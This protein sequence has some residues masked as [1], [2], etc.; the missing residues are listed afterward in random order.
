MRLACTHTH[1]C[2]P[3]QLRVYLNVAP[4]LSSERAKSCPFKTASTEARCVACCFPDPQPTYHIASSVRHHCSFHSL[5]PRMPVCESTRQETIVREG[6]RILG[7]DGLE[8]QQGVNT[9]ERGLHASNPHT[10]SP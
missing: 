2:I 1:A 4:F 10:R 3:K 6:R 9:R 8:K 5:F 7:C